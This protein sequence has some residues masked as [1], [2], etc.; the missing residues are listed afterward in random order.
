MNAAEE[1]LKD[2][3]NNSEDLVGLLKDAM[4]LVAYYRRLLEHMEMDTL[5]G[6]PSGNKF[7][8]RIAE[9]GRR[10]TG[11]G[12]IFFDVNDLK[13][14]N[15]TLGH[16]AGDLLLQKA[17]ESILHITG[18]SAQAYRIGGDEFVLLHTNC[19]AALLEALLVRWR[20]NL[21]RLNESDDGI[22]CSVAVGFALGGE[23]EANED[24]SQVLER[25]DQRMYVHKQQ[26]KAARQTPPA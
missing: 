10:T 17:A 22:H 5:T 1:F 4:Q 6:L 12:I 24:I 7:R 15:D 18:P 3:G 2:A 13:H 11:V 14:Y 9:I 25:A 26:M 21:A 20:D 19:V 8:S 23:G 16:K